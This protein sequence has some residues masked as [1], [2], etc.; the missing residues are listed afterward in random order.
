MRKEI[1]CALAV[2]ILI[3][4]ATS[5]CTDQGG[6]TADK[7]ESKIP[8][9]EIDPKTQELNGI[10]L[11][12]L[13]AIKRLSSCKSLAEK[14]RQERIPDQTIICTVG[15]DSINVG[16]YKR[17]FRQRQTTVRQQLQINQNLKTPLL[18][19]AKREG[20][21]LTQQ[22]KEKLL[23]QARDLTGQ[24]LEKAL[25]SQNIS[26]EKFEDDVLSMGLALKAA[27]L[28]IED[29]LI[30]DLIKM[31][32][33]VD[34]GR[35]SGLGKIAF[36]KYIEFKHSP[37]Y[38]KLIEFS[39][40]T[41]DQLKERLLEEFM[42]EE[43]IKKIIKQAPLQDKDVLDFYNKQKETFKHG[44]RIRWSQIVIASPT[45]SVGPLQ[46][47]R[48][49]VK[50]QRPDLKGAALEKE[51]EKVEKKQEDKARTL[52]KQAQAGKDFATLANENT[53]DIPMRAT[54]RGGDMGFM[55]LDD[56]KRSSILGFFAPY[57]EG[58]KPGQV[59]PELL[60]SDFGWH[61]VK[62]TADE[63]EGYY[64]FNEVKDQLKK[65]LASGNEQLAVNSWLAKKQNE[66]PIRISRE[67]D[68]I[69]AQVDPNKPT[70]DIEPA[71]APAATTPAET[72]A[73]TTP[74]ATAPTTSSP[75]APAATT[76][77]AK[78]AATTPAATTRPSAT[79]PAAQPVPT[80][81]AT[82]PAAN[83]APPASK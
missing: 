40:Q 53:D 38:E 83:T 72:K 34:A 3:S 80:A 23:Q 58:M 10:A 33:I 82:K 77:P 54:R 68:R 71:T 20:V 1:S 22:E 31:A 36:N 37:D 59:N 30:T 75:P 52:L 47:I 70:I 55:S 14:I 78:P 45:R 11:A 49:Q 41:P 46:D 81:P 43:M 60:R 9:V 4:A 16:D 44:R 35:K 13:T 25:K 15:G 61:I 26:V 39:E 66:V 5:S 51:I 65:E 79:T 32:L 42:M 18:E 29:R 74:A 21:T 56:I 50:L 19:R 57:L 6:K 12:N 17:M 67:F 48:T 2:F 63:A 64:P 28:G 69:L 76:T 7:S 62:L 27:S 24:S 8:V 73:A